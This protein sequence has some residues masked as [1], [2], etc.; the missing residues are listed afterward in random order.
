MTGARGKHNNV[1]LRV[2]HVVHRYGIAKHGGIESSEGIDEVV[3]K[4]IVVIQK[5]N[6]RR[7]HRCTSNSA[8]CAM[9]MAWRTA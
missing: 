1:G 5:D 9:A 4:R 6:M 8:P 2:Q 3:D 7:A